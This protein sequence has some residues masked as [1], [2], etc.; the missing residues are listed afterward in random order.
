MDYAETCSEK[1]KISEIK[2]IE[3]YNKYLISIM[4]L[5]ELWSYK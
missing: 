2:A 3:I 1:V 5:D 4:T